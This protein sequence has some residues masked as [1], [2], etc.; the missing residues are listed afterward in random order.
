M[1]GQ[2]PT[3]EECGL[4]ELTK[5]NLLLWQLW[6][7]NQRKFINFSSNNIWS[8]NIAGI[9]FVCREL[10]I[11]DK[12]EFAKRMEMIAEELFK[13]EVKGSDIKDKEN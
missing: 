2:R 12:Y 6:T 1:G 8:L 5:E 7:D 13:I 11:N 3:C 9:D 4:E 10:N